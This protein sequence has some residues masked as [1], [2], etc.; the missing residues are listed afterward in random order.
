ML[1]EPRPCRHAQGLG[2]A[3][4]ARGDGNPRRPKR[5]GRS[6]LNQAGLKSWSIL[7][8]LHE[9]NRSQGGYEMIVFL[10]TPRRHLR[11]P[12]RD[13]HSRTL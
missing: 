1:R 8:T 12:E 10:G 9:A 4:N 6:P 13:A 5:A 7:R 3:H 2:P 11:H